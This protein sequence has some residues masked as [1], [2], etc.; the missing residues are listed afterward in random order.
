M[1]LKID[2][3]IPVPTRTRNVRSPWRQLDPGDSAFVPG[4]RA[5]HLSSRLRSK[6]MRRDGYLFILRTLTEDGVKGVRVWR[7]DGLEPS[8][9]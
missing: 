8:T 9:E 6:A 3:G 4:V 1:D 5:P 7:V 2:K